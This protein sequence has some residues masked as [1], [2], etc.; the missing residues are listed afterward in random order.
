MSNSIMRDSFYL[1]TVENQGESVVFAA[2]KENLMFVL[3][4]PLIIF[5]QAAFHCRVF[6]CSLLF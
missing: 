3:E 5:C 6:F 2:H 4:I 1:T